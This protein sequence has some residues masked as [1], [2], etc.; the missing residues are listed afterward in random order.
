MITNLTISFGFLFTIGNII[1]D[2]WGLYEP[3]IMYVPLAIFLFLLIMQVRRPTPKTTVQNYFLNYFMF[4]A[5][6]NIVK[7][8]FY[9]PDI[10]QINDYVV[11]GIATLILLIFLIKWTI[12][13]RKNGGKV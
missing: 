11:C 12:Q 9:S 4:L 3:K 2:K 8:V 10:K 5:L 1:W 13:N 7:Q 6:S